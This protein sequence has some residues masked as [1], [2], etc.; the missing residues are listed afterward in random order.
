MGDNLEGA[1]NQGRRPGTFQQFRIFSEGPSERSPVGAND[2]NFGQFSCR[3]RIAT[4]FFGEFRAKM[5]LW[6]FVGDESK[7]V[8]SCL[9]R[10][11]R[12]R[13]VRKCRSCFPLL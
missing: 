5:V 12:C 1:D 6:S 2:P 9:K 10:M 8:L 11:R 3:S 4:L 7:T 13:T